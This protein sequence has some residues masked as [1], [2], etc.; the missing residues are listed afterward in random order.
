MTQLLK[1]CSFEFET[2]VTKPPHHEAFIPRIDTQ[3]TGRNRD[4]PSFHGAHDGSNDAFWT[5]RAT[6]KK[7]Q[8][9]IE[10]TAGPSLKAPNWNQSGQTSIY[11]P[12]ILIAWD[13]E[14]A[15]PPDTDQV[16]QG[17]IAT[18]DSDDLIDED[19][20][21]LA[22]DR[23]REMIKVRTLNNRDVWDKHH[24][25]AVPSAGPLYVEEKDWEIGDSNFMAEKLKDLLRRV[26]VSP[27]WSP[28][29]SA[30]QQPPSDGRDS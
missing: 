8:R 13:F 27:A 18:L 5:L 23:W 12:F 2:R 25:C 1:G 11:T 30:C 7:T 28:I 9:K 19:N 17:G 16:R 29:L 22:V 21:V 26:K 20:S 4:Q 15:S 3:S 14:G 6:I 24:P 10:E